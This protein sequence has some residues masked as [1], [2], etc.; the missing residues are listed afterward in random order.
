MR[1]LSERGGPGKL[2]SYWEQ[3][4]H[5]VVGQRGNLPVYEVRPEG[6]TG[7][8]R[9]LHRNLLLPCTLFFFQLNP[10]EPPLH[11]IRETVSTSPSKTVAGRPQI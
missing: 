4:I 3:Q 11:S 5:V 8:P 10:L 7:K 1:N 9:V 2:R 6:Q